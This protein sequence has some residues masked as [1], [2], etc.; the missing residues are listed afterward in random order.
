MT[1][2]P[3]TKLPVLAPKRS[4]RHGPL[5]AATTYA[6]LLIPLTLVLLLLDQRVLQGELL[7]LKPL[8]FQ[9]S[10]AVMTGTLLWAVGRFGPHGGRSPWVVWPA[11]AVAI[12]AVYEISFL[13]VQAARGVP[14]HFNR[15]TL[16]D[17]LGHALMQAGA[18]VLVLGAAFIGVVLIIVTLWRDGLRNPMML[19]T[20]LGLALGGALGG[21]TG[22]FIGM[23]GGPYVGTFSPTDPYLPVLG[24]SGTIGD[25]RVSHFFGLHTMQAMPLAA[26][27]L[28]QSVSAPARSLAL[29]GLAAVGTAFTLWTLTMAQAG[30]PL[31]PLAG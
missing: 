4:T 19:G 1:A 3:M 2:V 10:L 27:A 21:Y 28:P 31:I 14:S 26:L 15:E 18:S 17:A 25:L 9:M 16:F 24:W 13:M 22:G 11:T 20:G 23:N 29:V 8:K 12:T 30:A 6:L 7:W 5:S